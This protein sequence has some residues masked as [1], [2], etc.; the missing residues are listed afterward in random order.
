VLAVFT[1]ATAR[2]ENLRAV[3]REDCDPVGSLQGTTDAKGYRRMSEK[4]LGQLADEG[5]PMCEAF[6]LVVRLAKQRGWIPIGFR[7]IEL[8]DTFIVTVNGTKEERPDEI[9]FS[10]PPFHAS[11]IVNGWPGGIFTMIG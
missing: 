3:S 8:L 9:G 11:V 2:L 1:T 5:A 10:I 7:R 4:T 6:D